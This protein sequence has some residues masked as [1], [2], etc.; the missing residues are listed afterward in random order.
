MTL[1]SGV[2]TSTCRPGL[3]GMS[4]ME[5]LELVAAAGLEDAQTPE[6]AVEVTFCRCVSGKDMVCRCRLTL[7]NPH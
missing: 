4:Q 3:S 5:F 6:A 1:L 7:S 2:F